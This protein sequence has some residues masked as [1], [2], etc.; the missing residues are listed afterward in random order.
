MKKNTPVQTT[1]TAGNPHS[2]PIRVS[3]DGVDTS[4]HHEMPIGKKCNQHSQWHDSHT[5]LQTDTPEWADDDC[6]RY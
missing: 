1:S 5:M 4:R 3:R 2:F 6:D